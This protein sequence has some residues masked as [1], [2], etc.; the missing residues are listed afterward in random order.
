MKILITSD[1]YSP[2]VNGVVTSVVNLENELRAMGHE[3]KILTLSPNYRSRVV[4]D[5][6]YIG[7]VSAGLIYPEARIRASL[8]KKWIKDLIEWKPDIVHSQCEFSTFFMAKSIAKALNI[9][10]VHTYHT[11]YEDYVHYFSPSRK[12]GKLLVTEFTR[13]VATQTLTFVAP[14]KKVRRML[15]GYKIHCPIEIVPTGVE[16]R[17]FEEETSPE[18]INELKGKFGIAADKKVIV[19]VGRLAKEKNGDE[20]ILAHKLLNDKNT[21]LLFVGDGPYRKHLEKLVDD[22]SLRDNVVFAGMAPPEDIKDYYR[23]GDL[24][25]SASTSETQGLTY[26]EALAAGI[27]ILCR[28]DACLEDVVSNG[29]NGWQFDRIGE[30]RAFLKNY[31]EDPDMQKRMKENAR[32]SASKFSVENFAQSIEKIYCDA[33]ER[34]KNYGR[35]N[36]PFVSAINRVIGKKR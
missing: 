2:V 31:L 8:R 29:D 25:V 3:V 22:E 12:F 7:S 19:S 26:I 13:L 21:V 9:P 27:P 4:G 34:K 33:I 30:Y 16:L 36:I 17:H 14:T 20:L 18:R 32:K 24:F 35:I 11:V 10:L 28:R 15:L 23:L 6:T 5:I 1:W